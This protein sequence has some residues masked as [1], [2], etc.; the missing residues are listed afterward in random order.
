MVAG[1]SLTVAVLLLARAYSTFPGD[2][3][4][5]ERTQGI[6]GEWLDAVAGAVSRVGD[7]MVA[8]ALVVGL[9]LC[10]VLVRR[11]ADAGIAAIS[12][13]PMLA[14]FW[15]K[16][17]VGRP[18][19]EY[20]GLGAPPAT[21]SFPSG[22]A[23]FAIVFG[24]L[25]IYLVE[26]AVPSWRVRRAVQAGIGALVLAIG[27]SRVYLGAHWPSDVLGGYLLGALALL[28]LLW[29]RG[30]LAPGSAPRFPRRRLAA[31]ARLEE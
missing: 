3:G 20:L 9:V 22:H 27:M 25:L 17:L 21:M 19:P 7:F 16:E 2:R 14:V 6:Q 13:G 5:L 4:L 31:G 23:V 11:R 10:L 15:L 18:R 1:L 30:R 12:A 26:R 28:G 24:G 29:L 8:A